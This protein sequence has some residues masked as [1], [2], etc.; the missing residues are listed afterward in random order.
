MSKWNIDNHIVGKTYDLS[1]ENMNAMIADIE[2][3]K[4]KLKKANE[5]IEDLGERLFHITGRY[6]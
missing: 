2:L 1:Q 6:E 5:A 4:A 3:L